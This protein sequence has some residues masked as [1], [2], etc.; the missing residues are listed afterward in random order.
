[1]FEQAGIFGAD[2]VY[3]EAVGLDRVGHSHVVT[4]EDGSAVTSRAVIIATGVAYRRLGIQ[5]LE[6]YSGSGVFYGAAAS[7]VQA[8]H[9]KAVHIVG[10]ANSAG[11]AALHLAQHAT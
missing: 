4:L 3:G 1:M 11:Q 5:A 6:A 9:G 8:L 10:G 2:F 7:E